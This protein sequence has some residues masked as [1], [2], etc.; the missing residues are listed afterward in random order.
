MQQGLQGQ[1]QRNCSHSVCTNPSIR[2]F[3]IP[4]VIPS[5]PQIF[6]ALNCQAMSNLIPVYAA[7]RSVF[8]K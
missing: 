6:L 8:R 2:P 1:K 7:R 5:H 3:I 4:N